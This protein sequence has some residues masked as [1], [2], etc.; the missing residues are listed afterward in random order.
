MFNTHYTVTIV[1]QIMDRRTE[2]W[3][4]W[5]RRQGARKHIMIEINLSIMPGAGAGGRSDA[6]SRVL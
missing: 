6:V 4:D 1:A 3:L 5:V 2:E